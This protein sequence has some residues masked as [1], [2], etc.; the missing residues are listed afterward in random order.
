M[1]SRPPSARPLGGAP[2]TMRGAGAV[3]L[4][5]ALMLAATSLGRVELAVFGLTLLLLTAGGWLSLRLAG[6]VTDVD[7]SLS[8]D[9]ASVGGVSH[10]RARLVLSARPVPGGTWRD[11]L[12]DA[13][14]PVGTPASPDGP[15]G[16]LR[17]GARGTV[18]VSYAV[19]G[20]RRGRHSLGPLETVAVDPFGLARRRLTAG[21]RTPVTIVP[22]VVSLSALPGAPGA[23][24]TSHTTT[25][26]H[27]QGADN[28]IPRPYAPGDSMRRIHW[29]A[30]AHHGSFMV[31]EE[32]RETTPRA[33]VVFDRGAARWRPDAARGEDEG[34]EAAVTVCVSAAWSLTRDGYSVEVVDSDGAPIAAVASQED[35]SALLVAFASVAPRGEDTLAR[36]ASGIGN[37][38]A[39]PVVVVTG[40]MSAE[41]VAGLAPVAVQASRAVLLS[42]DPRGDALERAARTGWH[43]ARLRIDVAQAWLAATR[44]GEP[45]GDPR[46]GAPRAEGVSAGGGH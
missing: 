13:L 37:W 38:S 39:A 20:M 40:R 21:A 4:G 10:V 14:R 32:E 22:G 43:A 6:R 8:T 7:R 31:R 45:S 15:V 36:L 24:G 26:R 11:A 12:P 16:D 35:M 25:D 5:V 18:E 29:R 27:G 46:T 42:A 34:F 1:T 41:D 30:S 2:L 3:V 23:A 33:I 28:L 19:M 44:P 17:P 9:V